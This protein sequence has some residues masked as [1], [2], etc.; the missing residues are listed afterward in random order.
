MFT[1][2]D[3][4]ALV[5]VAAMGACLSVPVS[6]R[7]DGAFPDSQ[8]VLTPA[9]APDEIILV[10]NFGLVQSEDG[11]ATWL[12]ACEQAA[13][14]YGAFYQFGLPP[15]HRLYAVANRQVVFSDDHSCGWAAAGGLV[16]EV[17]GGVS[18]LWVDRTVV[19]RVLAVNI[20]CC[21]ADQQRIHSVVESLDG[22][23]TFDTL[24]YRADRGATITGVESAGSDP[25]TIYVTLV[26]AP[27]DGG[28]PPPILAHTIDG[29]RSWHL[30][31]L[32]GQ[33]GA[34]VVRLVAVDPDNPQKVFLLWNGTDSQALVMT[35]DAG[36]TASKTLLPTGVMKAF[37]RLANGTILVSTDNDST[38]GLFRSRDG[39]ATFDP[40]PAPP[41][42][43]AMSERAARIYA[44]TD[45]VAEGYA[46][47]VSADEGSTWTALRS[48]Q[49]VRA[50]V[51][52]LK[53]AC[54]TTCD[55]EA[56]LALWSPDICSAD[57]PPISSGVGGA[58]GAADGG[59]PKEGSHGGGCGC[60]VASAG[61]PGALRG[62]GMAVVWLLA[63]FAVGRRGRRR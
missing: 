36:A 14:M 33:I 32:T 28:A 45:N 3:R 15:R 23:G 51:P 16:P 31:D 24:M 41:H 52:C 39:G 38:A 17:G 53:A 9:D 40:V 21:D 18:D 19:D 42:I 2:G 10:T 7:A 43:R 57:P 62:V 54:Q 12:W 8:T 4:L 29:G 50:I 61:S 48:Y 27:S 44:A 56:Q 5:G 55:V 20:T 58:P 60:A 30:V 26:G 11:G 47:G 13:N 46:L 22:G 25:D 1:G 49:D 59:E 6:A 37:L 63:G 35:T 34:G